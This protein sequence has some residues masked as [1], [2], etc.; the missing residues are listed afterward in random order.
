MGGFY[1]PVVGGLGFGAIQIRAFDF[2][3]TSVALVPVH[4]EGLG[5]EGGGQLAVRVAAVAVG[6]LSPGG[7]VVLAV[8]VVAVAVVAVAS[9]GV[10][11][12]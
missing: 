4:A 6:L 8:A 2:P 3:A 5:A 10:A 11:S 1:V 9:A 12:A 7:G